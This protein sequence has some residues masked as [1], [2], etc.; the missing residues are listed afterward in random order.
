M[1]IEELQV[2]SN[3][4]E[5]EKRMKLKNIAEDVFNKHKD[6]LNIYQQRLKY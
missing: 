1:N 2:K 6:T 5:A 3:T 4:E